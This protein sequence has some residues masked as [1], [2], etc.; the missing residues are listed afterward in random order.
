MRS[1][2]TTGIEANTAPGELEGLDPGGE[3]TLAMIDGEPVIVCRQVKDYEAALSA[4]ADMGLP[5]SVSWAVAEAAG[6]YPGAQEG[7]AEE[8]DWLSAV[9]RPVEATRRLRSLHS[10]HY[11]PRAG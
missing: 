1:Y 8:L 9:K 3:V 6:F 11:T 5:V 4:A 7:A 2:P 10:P